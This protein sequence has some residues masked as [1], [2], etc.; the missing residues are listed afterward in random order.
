MDNL[1]QKIMRCRALIEKEHFVE[2]T[3]LIY[4]YRTSLD[5]EH[6]FDHLPSPQEIA[7]RKPNTCGWCSGQED[8]MI[9]GGV[10]LDMYI[11][12]NDEEWAHK[13]YRGLKLCGT[14]S[15]VPGFVAR[16]VSPIDGKSFYPE[17][18]RDQYTHYVFALWH[19]F[20]SNISTAEEKSEI[21]KLLSDVADFCEKYITPENDYM[22]PLADFGQPCSSVCKLWNVKAHEI[23]R[24]PMFYAA[25][26]SVSGKQHYLD[27]CY[28]YADEAAEKSML[29]GNYS[30]NSFALLQ[31]MCSCSLIYHTIPDAALKEK[32]RTVMLA[33]D[34]YFNFNFCRAAD[35]SYHADFYAPMNNWRTPENAIELLGCDNWLPEKPADYQLAY[36]TVRDIGEALIAT[37]LMPEPNVSRLRKNIFRFILDRLEVEKHMSYAP[38]YS[39]AAWYKAKK[40]GIEL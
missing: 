2:S 21:V 36:R 40:L 32:Y 20:H 10:A 26:Y 28:R 9:N 31:M 29:L 13:I 30:Y 33:A 8:S 37:L 14:I 12:A 16:S 22:L 23:A 24:L 25:A 17:S 3:S 34:E 11:D 38:I 39:A 19:F 4:D 5:H 1:E 35:S 6:R 7:E 15:G 27:M 18:S